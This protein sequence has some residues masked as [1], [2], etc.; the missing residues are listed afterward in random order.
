MA[1]YSYIPPTAFQVL[2]VSEVIAPICA[3]LD[4]HSNSQLAQTC[5]DLFHP[6]IDELWRVQDSLQNLFDL[7]PSEVIRWKLDTSECHWKLVRSLCIQH[8]K[9]Y[10]TDHI[11]SLKVA[12]GLVAPNYWKRFAL[13]SDRI[14]VLECHSLPFLSPSSIYHLSQNI[15]V[16]NRPLLPHLQDLTVHQAM[17]NVQD[18]QFVQLLLGPYL[19]SINVKVTASSWVLR[20]TRPMVLKAA[21]GLCR[22]ISESTSDRLR[23]LQLDLPTYDAPSVVTGLVHLL[24][25]AASLEYFKFRGG[26]QDLSVLEAIARLPNLR[27]VALPHWREPS[28]TPTS[29]GIGSVAVGGRLDF[30][31]LEVLEAQDHLIWA[32]LRD[33]ASIPPLAI[34]MRTGPPPLS[35]RYP[36]MSNFLLVVGRFAHILTTVEVRAYC[37]EDGPSEAPVVIEPLLGC[38]SLTSIHVDGFEVTEDLKRLGIGNAIGDAWPLLEVFIWRTRVDS[39]EM[40]T[41]MSVLRALAKSCPRLRTVDVPISLTRSTLGVQVIEEHARTLGHVIVSQWLPKLNDKA[42]LVRLLHSVGPKRPAEGWVCG[43][44]KDHGRQQEHLF[45]FWMSVLRSVNSLNGLGNR[46]SDIP[47]CTCWM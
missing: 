20:K 35:T 43:V 34:R 30:P 1:P 17:C 28:G 42:R 8:R 2:C 47:R 13:Y 29:V 11:F 26:L 7:L 40:G 39:G 41:D 33:A 36:E 15:V 24:E 5:S 38:P 21:G 45:L 12:T 4:G 25:G 14:R 46:V 6:A 9:G 32:I 22:A 18:V 37:W 44:I 19:K 16:H 10:P 31:S 23:T 27:H 3:S